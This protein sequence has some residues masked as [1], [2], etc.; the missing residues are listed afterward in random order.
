MLWLREARRVRAWGPAGPGLTARRMGAV[1]AGRVV[2]EARTP[3]PPALVKGAGSTVTLLA[4]WGAA[5]GTTILPGPR[6]PGAPA[7]R[8]VVTVG[9]RIWATVGPGLAAG[10]VARSTGAACW[11]EAAIPS[12]PLMAAP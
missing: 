5:T 6:G 2:R 4:A 12:L 7:L 1:R 9:M 11:P 10:L 8:P 3:G